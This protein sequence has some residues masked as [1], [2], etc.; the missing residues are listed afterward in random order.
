[1][2]AAQ[3]PF[4]PIRAPLVAQDVTGVAIRDRLKNLTAQRPGALPRTIRRS[5]GPAQRAASTTSVASPTPIAAT[6]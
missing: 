4:R 1:M 5:S 2:T 3:V 6:R